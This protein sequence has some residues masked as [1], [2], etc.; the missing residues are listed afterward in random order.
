MKYIKI[1]AVIFVANIVYSLSNSHIYAAEKT[2]DSSAIMSYASGV[3]S[4]TQTSTDH[5]KRIV[6]TKV[7]SKNNSPLLSNVD[8]FVD[9]A[10]KYNLD[11]YL[12]PSITW[13]ESSHGPK[14]I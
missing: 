3:G 13:L 8:T 6:L 4:N 12:L 5:V 7:L 1:F 2:S 10:T 11:P 9:V 14:L